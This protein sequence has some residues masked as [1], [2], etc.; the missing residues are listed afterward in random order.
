LNPESNNL[1]TP[2]SD[3]ELDFRRNLSG[4]L[5]LRQLSTNNLTVSLTPPQ[6]FTKIRV[7]KFYHNV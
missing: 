6:I 4:W 3:A 1:E 7:E 5:V 2:N